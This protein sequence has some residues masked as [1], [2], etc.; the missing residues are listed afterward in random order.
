MT[1]YSTIEAPQ[2]NYQTVLLS[3]QLGC[4][5]FPF[6]LHALPGELLEVLLPWKYLLCPDLMVLNAVSK[7][8]LLCNLSV[9]SQLAT[10]L[11]FCS[12]VVR[13][14]ASLV[15]YLGVWY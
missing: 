2:L 13:V 15:P 11:N 14:L 12:S 5:I 1:Y 9:I 10:L 7:A 4:D 3:S 6:P 8:R